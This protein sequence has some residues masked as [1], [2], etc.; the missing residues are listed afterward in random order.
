ME[1]KLEFRRFAINSTMKLL[2][3]PNTNVIY[4]LNFSLLGEGTLLTG[5]HLVS[6]QVAGLPAEAQSYRFPH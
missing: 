6:N 2:A 4:F 3:L 1:L 5:A